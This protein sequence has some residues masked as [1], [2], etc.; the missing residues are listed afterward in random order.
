M[1][2]LLVEIPTYQRPRILGRC[3]AALLAQTYQD[4][5]VL[6]TNDNPRERVDSDPVTAVWLKY[7]KER[8]KVW[9]EDG[10]GIGQ[11]YSHNLA[12]W[13]SP[14]RNYEFVLRLDDDVLLNNYAIERMMRF[15]DQNENTAAVAGLWFDTEHYE[16]WYSCRDNPTTEQWEKDLE[17]QGKLVN[18]VVSNWHQRLYHHS[19]Q[20]T[21]GSFGS[22]MRVEHLYGPWLYRSEIMR[23]VGG[24]PEI[25][26]K[27]VHHGFETESSYRLHMA[28]Y[29]LY[30]L[31]YVTADHLRAP[32][33]IRS[34]GTEVEHKQRLVDDPLRN[35]RLQNM[36]GAYK[37]RV[38]V[39][40]WGQHTCFVGGGAKMYFDVLKA[41]S[42]SPYIDVWPVGYTM[43]LNYVNARFGIELDEYGPPPDKL[44]V[45]IQ[46]GDDIEWFDAM[47]ETSMVPEARSKALFVYYP[48]GAKSPR[49]ND[50][51]TIITLSDYVDRIML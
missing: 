36:P 45:L 37:E 12:I 3:L 18:G 6:I 29:E 27:G 34:K 17:L 14:W 22:P 46:F 11:I 41:L 7:H 15:M 39:G 9:T 4:F 16:D 33:G 25:Y 26:S 40:L 20:E 24:F 35:S 1:N 10:L 19:R 30:V 5:D 43:D 31:P 2:T 38:K 28:G 44:D 23:R 13:Q 42:K 21:D 51:Q 49:V 48:F 32:G 8:R 47:R 50:F